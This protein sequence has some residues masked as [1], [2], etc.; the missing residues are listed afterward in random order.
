[1]KS[2]KMKRMSAIAGIAIM[3]TMGLAAC[4]GGSSSAGGDTTCKEFKAMSAEDRR[5]V[6][7]DFA[8][9]EG[10]DLGDATTEE[11]DMGN[12]F[13]AG[14]CDMVKDEN[15]KLKD[16]DEDAMDLPDL[17]DLDTNLEDLESQL[18]DLESELDSL[19]DLD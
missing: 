16:I 7:T 9:Q 19:G 8:K 11:I 14:M 10:E 3:S 12:E 1:M 13:V 17:G 2:S 15:V 6:I 18:N 5:T 4:G